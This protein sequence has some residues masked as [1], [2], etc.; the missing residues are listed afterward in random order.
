MTSRRFAGYAK[1]LRHVELAD[2]AVDKF[3]SRLAPGVRVG[4][5]IIR[6]ARAEG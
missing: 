1:R 5:V 6:I 4:D 2:A 3:F